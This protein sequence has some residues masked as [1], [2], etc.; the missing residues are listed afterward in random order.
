VVEPEEKVKAKTQ[1]LEKQVIEAEKKINLMIVTE[2]KN[3][4][5]DNEPK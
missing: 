2:A 3:S 5:R 4:G 1:L